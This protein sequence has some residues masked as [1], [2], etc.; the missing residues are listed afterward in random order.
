M[1][2]LFDEIG[3]IFE[4]LTIAIFQLCF[5]PKMRLSVDLEGRFT[6]Y[7]WPLTTLIQLKTKNYSDLI[8]PIVFSTTLVALLPILAW[9]AGSFRS[10]FVFS[11]FVL[12]L[13]LVPFL[14]SWLCDRLYA[15]LFL[16][17]AEIDRLRLGTCKYIIAKLDFTNLIK[18]HICKFDSDKCLSR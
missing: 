3:I 7:Y 12:P 11:P 10:M 18:F 6:G 15:V 9:I 16:G 17:S 1:H 4:P 2:C 13:F 5:L 14:G 8:I